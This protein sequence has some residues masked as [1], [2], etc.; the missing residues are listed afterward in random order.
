ML[1]GKDPYILD[2]VTSLHL[3]EWFRL[4]ALLMGQE[5][6]Y[7]LIRGNSEEDK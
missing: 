3:G 7:P 5:L 2:V 4:P 1:G 6:R